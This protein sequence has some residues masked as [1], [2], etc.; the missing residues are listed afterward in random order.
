M[1]GGT[2]DGL[3]LGNAHNV[4][5]IRDNVRWGSGN[6]KAGRW[7]GWGLTAPVAFGAPEVYGV[8]DILNAVSHWANNCKETELTVE[9]CGDCVTSSRSQIG[10]ITF[11]SWAS[12]GGNSV[13]GGASWLFNNPWVQD[14]VS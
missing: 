13:G 14:R 9:S 7:L 12:L 11:G 4:G 5:F 2:L 8:V 10:G 1:A 3:S 6:A